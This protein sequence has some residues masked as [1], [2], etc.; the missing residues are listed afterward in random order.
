M[1]LLLLI[2]HL[3]AV[4]LSFYMFKSEAMLAICVFIFSLVYLFGLLESR[5]DPHRIYAHAMVG[6]VLFFIVGAL[7]L[8]NDLSKL[9]LKFNLSRTLMIILGSAG[10]IQA[11]RVKRHFK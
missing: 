8:L 9:Q 10:L 4:L 6:G 5:N 11:L 7:T 3:V 2:E 1:K